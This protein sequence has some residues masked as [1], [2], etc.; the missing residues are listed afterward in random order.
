MIDQKGFGSS[1]GIVGTGRS[2][3]VASLFVLNIG[4]AR[5]LS[6][7]GYGSFQQVFLFNILF[8]IFSLGIPETVT[9][10]LPRLSGVPRSAFLGQTI[11]LLLGLSAAVGLVLGI[12]APMFAHLQGNPSIT[13][14]IRL[15]GIYGAF[16][17]LSS[18]ADPV[19]I[20]FR[21]IK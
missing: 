8:V 15:F 17:V 5:S 7:E 14:S 20:Y 18:F 12:G 6:V 13:M 4:L 10:F 2:I 19:F 3:Y 11:M 21:H 16:Y 9:F 1:V